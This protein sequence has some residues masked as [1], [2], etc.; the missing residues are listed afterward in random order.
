MPAFNLRFSTENYE[1]NTISIP[2][3]KDSLSSIK[4]NLRTKG[5]GRVKCV[6]ERGESLRTSTYEST[7]GRNFTGVF[8]PD[9][10]DCF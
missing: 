10:P 6:P 3:S 4:S 8:Y 7:R 9:G 5:R 1:K 2:T